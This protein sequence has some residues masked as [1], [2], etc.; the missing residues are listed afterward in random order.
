MNARS[1]S[2]ATPLSL[3]SICFRNPATVR[4]GMVPG[5]RDVI[6]HKEVVWYGAVRSGRCPVSRRLSR[7]YREVRLI[8]HRVPVWPLSAGYRARTQDVGPCGD[9]RSNFCHPLCPTGH[10]SVPCP[11]KGRVF[12]EPPA[13]Q[14]ILHPQAQASSRTGGWAGSSIPPVPGATPFCQAASYKIDWMGI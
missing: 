2:N 8:V 1:G 6:R 12:L 7:G 5:H 9:I 4:D 13:R 3:T 11:W 10:N 14:G